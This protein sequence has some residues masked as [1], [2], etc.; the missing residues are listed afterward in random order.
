[1]DQNNKDNDA[2]DLSDSFK[3]SGEG[4]ANIGT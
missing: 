4:N 1:M 2:I 3:D